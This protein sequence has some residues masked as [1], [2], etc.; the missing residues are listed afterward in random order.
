MAAAEA[1]GYEYIVVSDHSKSSTIAGG[2][3]VDE[4]RAQ[5]GKIRELQPRHKIRIL[6]GSECDILADGSMDFPDEVLSELDIVLA[7][8]HSRFKQSRAEMTSRICRALAHP[9]V[10]ILAHP[11]GRLIGSRD[12]YDVDMDAVL[13][14]AREHGK[15]VEINCS[16]DRLD[17]N[18][19]HARRAADLGIPIAISTDTHYLSNLDFLELGLGVARRAWI[20]PGQVLNAWPLDGLLAWAHQ[21]R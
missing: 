5:R 4:L 15:A 20:G 7:A 14:T 9:L 11:T 6:A 8:V 21:G 17:L 10:N 13:A 18:D 19:V 12:P 3:T 16:P 2:L 1:H